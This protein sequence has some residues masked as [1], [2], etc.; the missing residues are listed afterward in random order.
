MV[1]EMFPIASIYP[2]NILPLEINT[3]HPNRIRGVFIDSSNPIITGA[4][5][6]AYI[7][8]FKKLDLLVL[9][10]V[11]M[12]E[13]AKMADYILPA[14]SQ[15]EKYEAS[16]FNFEFPAN[17]FQFRHPIVKPIGDTLPE[18]EIYRRLIIAMGE[19]APEPVPVENFSF[20]EYEARLATIPLYLAVRR[21]ATQN[22]EEVS[23]AGIIP[24]EGQ[25]LGDALFEKIVTTPSG[26]IVSIHDYNVT[27]DMIKTKDKKNK[28]IYF[29]INS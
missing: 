4:D 24:K 14:S 17:F 7:E 21:Y 10:D 23:K 9:I 26:T 1:T 19:K 20:M 6:Q 15:F 13:T 5:S 12:T 8:A 29:R 27:W 28:F 11:C 2:P 22:K 3:E 16:F 25:S 18:S